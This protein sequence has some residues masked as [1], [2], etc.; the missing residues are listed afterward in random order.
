MGRVRGAVC[1][2]LRQVPRVYAVSRA[3]VSERLSLLLLAP[4]G[5]ILRRKWDFFPLHDSHHL[6]HLGAHTCRGDDREL[7]NAG[8]MGVSK[9]SLSD[10]FW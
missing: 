4:N 10:G 2:L 6:G 9:H 3:R 7:L 5:T 8:R 1:G